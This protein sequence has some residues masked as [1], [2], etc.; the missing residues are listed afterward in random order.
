MIIVY[1]FRDNDF[2]QIIEKYLDE[3]G[4]FSY[5][6]Y[7]QMSDKNKLTEI[8]YKADFRVSKLSKYEKQEVLKLLKLSFIT[9]IN[10]IKPNSNWCTAGF[11]A[12]NLNK[13]RDYILANIQ[14]KI[15][16]S[17]YGTWKNGEYVYYFPSNDKYITI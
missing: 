15:V 6:W 12:E 10:R 11:T 7:N 9:Y 17:F 8:L 13:D 5:L 3:G 14:I 1:T 4:P 2:T 16:E